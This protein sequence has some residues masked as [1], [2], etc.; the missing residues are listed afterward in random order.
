MRLCNKKEEIAMAKRLAQYACYVILGLALSYLECLIPLD[1]AIPGIKLGLGN[2]VM[3]LLLFQNAPRVAAL[4]NLC[5]ILLSGLLFGNLFGILYGLCGGVCA[6]IAMWAAKK[7]PQVGP[8]GCSIAG[9]VL[10]NFGQLL[11]AGIVL[12]TASVVAYLPFLLA[13]GIA[14]GCAVG[15][16]AAFLLPR[17]KSLQKK[18]TAI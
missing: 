6:F 17:I 10:H 14:A 1:A 12:G 16:A 15:I 18:H 5:R 2:L 4:T 11:A 8:I 3:V 7:A 9:G 13:G